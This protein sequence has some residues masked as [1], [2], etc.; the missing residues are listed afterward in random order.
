MRGREGTV[1]KEVGAL[2][3]REGAVMVKGKDA[4]RLDSHRTRVEMTGLEGVGEAVI[5]KPTSAGS[6]DEFIPSSN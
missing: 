4:V 3:V 2:M 5:E 1:I 6:P